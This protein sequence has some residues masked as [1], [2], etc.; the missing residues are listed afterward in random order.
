MV[1]NIIP[2]GTKMSLKRFSSTRWSSHDRVLIVIQEK[3]LAM[4]KTLN[5]LITLKGSDRNMVSTLE[6]LPQIIT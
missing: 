5:E 6:S 2:K 1:R 3:Y 4:I